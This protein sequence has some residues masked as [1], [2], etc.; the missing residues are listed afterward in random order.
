M[1]TTFNFEGGSWAADTGWFQKR[2]FGSGCGA[3]T[4]KPYGLVYWNVTVAD[5]IYYVDCDCGE[6]FFVLSCYCDKEFHEFFPLSYW[7]R[8][9]LMRLRDDWFL[10]R[11][12]AWVGVYFFRFGV[13]AGSC[14]L[15]LIFVVRVLV[16]CS[17]LLWWVLIQ[18]I[19]DN[20][21]ILLVRFC[22]SHVQCG[23]S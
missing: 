17:F 5:C 3:G 21:Q 11:V 7:G 14:G 15:N 18:S 20:L 10:V 8:G 12:R 16:G 6:S 2:R 4:H 22:Q 23:I 19:T 9:G 1:R 13:C